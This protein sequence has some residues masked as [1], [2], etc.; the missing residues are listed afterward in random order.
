[1]VTLKNDKLK[2]SFPE[3]HEEATC[4]IEFQRT[5]RVPDNDRSYPLPPGLGAFPLLHVEDYTDK[6]PHEW[7]KRGGV[8]LPTYQAEALW[9]KFKSR[10]YPFAVK[11]AAGKINAVTGEGWSNE[12]HGQ[13]QDYIILP[14]Q[15]WLDGFYVGD[16]VV[17]QFVATPLGKGYSAEEQITGRADFGGIQVVVYPMKA[18]AADLLF[19]RQEEEARQRQEEALRQRQK[20]SWGEPRF[21]IS[22][23]NSIGPGGNMRE[24]IH[25]NEYGDDIWET[26]VYSRCFVHLLNSVQYK[27]VTGQRPPTRPPTAADYT[28]AGLPWFEDYRKDLRPFPGSQILADLLSIGTKQPQTGEKVIRNTDIV[29]PQNVVTLGQGKRNVAEGNC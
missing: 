2:F 9:I 13:P 16:G 25:A 26:S 10:G 8:F 1:M 11:V 17:R 14:Q 7:A 28:K 29:E 3:V 27:A 24:A 6:L 19:R 12:L 5:L 4:V 20:E 18:Q 21:H 22:D 23:R 15:K